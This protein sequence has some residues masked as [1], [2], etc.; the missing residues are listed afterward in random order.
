MKYINKRVQN[1]FLASAATALALAAFSYSDLAFA[2]DQDAEEASVEE[3]IVTG[4]R[5]A[6]K[7]LTGP[8]PVSVIDSESLATSG[9]LS[10]GQ[11]LREM[12]SVAGGA[13][14]TQINNGG[15]GSMRI[16]LRGLGAAR[17]LVL[18][19]GR[20]M[21]G[22]GTG[23]TVDM[24]SFPTAMIERVE[25]LRDGASAVYGSDAVAGVVNVITRKDFD[26]LELGASYGGSDRGDGERKQV[27]ALLGSTSDAGNWLA[28]FAYID[29]QPVWAKDRDFSKQAYIQVNGEPVTSG[30]SALPW[31]RANVDGT[32]MTYGPEYSSE[33]RPYAG[34]SDTYNYAP[35]NYQRQKNRRWHGDFVGNTNLGDI[36]FM[37]DVVAT[38][39]VQVFHRESEARLAPQP[40]APYAFYGFSA[41]YAVDNAYNPTGFEIV[42]WRR[43]MVEDSNRVG[44]TWLTT[45]RGVVGLEGTSDSGW[46]WSLSYAWGRTDGAENYGNI[47]D[48]EK[49][50]NA[51][52]PTQVVDGQLQCVNDSAYCVPLNIWGEDSVTQE[53]ID[54]LTFIEK[55]KWFSEQQVY[56]FDMVKN[57]LFSLPAGDVGL[58]IGVNHR[59]E[60]GGYTPDSRTLS[61][62]DKGAA[63]GA[64]SSNTLGSYNV[65]EVY[66]EALIPVV[67]NFDITA[68]GRYSKYNT[69]GST[70]KGKIGAEY[71]P[72][73]DLLLRGGYSQSFRAPTISNLFGGAGI[74]FPGVN[75]PCETNPTAFCIA[76]GVPA[77]GFDTG[78]S[79]L[80]VRTL[81]GGNP[82]VEPEEATTYTLGFVYQP[83]EVP[84][85]SIVADYYNIKLTNAI[86]TLG[87]GFVLDQCAATG[88]YCEFVDRFGAGTEEGK[89]NLID[90]RLTNV[91]GINTQGVDFSVKYNGIDLGFGTLG[92][93]LEG[94]YLLEMDKIQA[95]G[96]VIDHLGRFRDDQLGHFAKWRLN[97]NASLTVNDLSTSVFVRY[98][99]DVIE[100]PYDYGVGANVDR[101]LEGAIYT[102][103]N[104]GYK[105]IENV[106]ISVGIEN[107]FD[108]QP[109]LSFDGF[110]DNTDVR[111][112]DTMGRYFYGGL[113]ASF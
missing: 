64:A 33:L 76:D 77:G 32:N 11:I 36:G 104:M 65:T 68:A 102:D 97:T 25:V 3:V 75:D 26:G 20:R 29:Q 101:T 44:N 56:S 88:D 24:N 16:S 6:R 107:V 70:F 47:Y 19:N 34:S 94:T 92:L 83:S 40:L 30:S 112:F 14:T 110:N 109:S 98:I 78:G 74:G 53:M 66:G 96:S 10:I 86:D 60:R 99:D 27:Y 108:I 42:D 48:L 57:D 100:T 105:L 69:F 28:H 93:G 52:G 21:I 50:A 80:Q 4:S 106:T 9:Q 12:P 43:R 17:T 79:T 71:R 55:N 2:Q 113:K 13:Q 54:Y 46:D 81:Y 95:D 59:I 41:P 72:I 62:F 87:V 39:E 63:T 38:A 73:E 18:V 8:S 15:D 61:L 31:V 23:G 58:A 90:N 22:T 45:L 91:G 49:V 85:L 7:D 111:T 5:I 84:G 67:E 35:D 103:V 37:K 51:V 1:K 82:E 89:P